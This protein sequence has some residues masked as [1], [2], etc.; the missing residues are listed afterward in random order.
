M[1]PSSATKRDDDGGACRVFARR[2]NHQGTIV[3]AQQGLGLK[4]VSEQLMPCPRCMK[5]FVGW[6][7]QMTPDASA[8][9]VGGFSEWG[10][11]VEGVRSLNEIG[12]LVKAVY[13]FSSICVH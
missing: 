12:V 9:I 7:V 13:S 1:L 4:Y 3:W 8:L 6:S 2:T 10:L 5:S 11:P